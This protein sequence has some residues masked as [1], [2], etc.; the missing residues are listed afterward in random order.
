MDMLLMQLANYF[1]VFLGVRLLGKRHIHL[2]FCLLYS[3]DF[4]LETCQIY[5]PIN[6]FVSIRYYKSYQSRKQ[7]HFHIY[8]IGH[9]YVFEKLP[10]LYPFLL[11]YSFFIDM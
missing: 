6:T 7:F 8:I 1:L 9:L 5:T 2:P 4:P 11:R 10:V 3:R